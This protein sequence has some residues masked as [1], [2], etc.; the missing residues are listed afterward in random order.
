M[1]FFGSVKKDGFYIQQIKSGLERLNCLVAWNVN[2]DKFYSE[3]ENDI[4]RV[5]YQEDKKFL[6][7]I[8]DVVNLKLIDN[9]YSNYFE[10]LYSTKK[11]FKLNFKVSIQK[12][13]ISRFRKSVKK[14][15]TWR[16]K[17]KKSTP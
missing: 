2:I 15:P 14:R 10:C 4:E 8:S 3:F 17:S 12:S 6:M 5:L 11:Y 16:I 13:F 9:R 1:I 7:E